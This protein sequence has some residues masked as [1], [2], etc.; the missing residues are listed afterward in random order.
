M[1]LLPNLKLQVLTT[2]ASTKEYPFFLP[3]L[4]IFQGSDRNSFFLCVLHFNVPS[5]VSVRCTTLPP[6]IRPSIHPSTHTHTSLPPFP[7]I[8][9][10]LCRS[11]VLSFHHTS[12]ISHPI[13]SGPTY[14]LRNYRYVPRVY[15]YHYS[16]YFSLFLLFL[17]HPN[18]S[19]AYSSVFLACFFSHHKQSRA[20]PLQRLHQQQSAKSLAPL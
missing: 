3:S 2:S 10:S 16:Y 12:Y 6:I 1:Y 7:S 8:L 11:F 4:P 19:L 13:V 20:S 17:L 9:I 14:Q 15:Y 5:Q 18:L